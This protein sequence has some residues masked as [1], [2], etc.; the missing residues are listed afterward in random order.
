MRK[1]GAGL[2]RQGDFERCGIAPDV[3]DDVGIA[4]RPQDDAA[5]GGLSEEEVE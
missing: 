3:P 2:D 1:I 4:V 5:E